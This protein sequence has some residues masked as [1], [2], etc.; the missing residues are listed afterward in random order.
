MGAC[1]EWAWFHP[2]KGIQRFYCGS[3]NCYR[4]K[5]RTIFW[6]RRVRLI[7]ALIE[8]YGLLRFFTLTLDPELIEGNPW[9]YI[10]NPWSK[11]RKRLNRRFPGWKFVAVLERHKNRDVPHIHGF[12]DI[13]MAQSEWSK[14]WH[15]SCGGKVVWIERVKDN[16]TMGDYVSKQLEVAKYVGKDCIKATYEVEEDGEKKKVRT[17]W[18]SK[19]TKAKF[20]LT[21]EP[22]WCIIKEPVYN[23]EGLT[24]HGQSVERSINGK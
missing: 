12:T 5:C 14:Q 17:L 3:G 9:V 8:E 6:S 1:G 15:E 13:W 16:V 2:D 22:G 21:S 20:E 7:T 10:H 4:D 11:L 23:E 19:D 24:S 18:R